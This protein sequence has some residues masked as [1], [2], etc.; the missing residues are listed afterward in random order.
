MLL[1]VIVC[2]QDLISA[3][4]EQFKHTCTS[5]VLMHASP[6]RRL[7]LFYTTTVQ[8]APRPTGKAGTL[9]MSWFGHLH[10]AVGNPYQAAYILLTDFPFWFPCLSGL[11]SG[12]MEE[13]LSLEKISNFA[14][15]VSRKF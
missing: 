12:L 4:V 2:L 3:D 8:T 15:W 13:K 1:F 9:L 7:A 10:S 5:A 6:A 11:M 14:P